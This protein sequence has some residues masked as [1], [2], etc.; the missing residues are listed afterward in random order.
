MKVLFLDESGD[1]SLITIER[2]YPLFVL[3]GV[4]VDREYARKIVEPRLREFKQHLFG[5]EDLVLHTAD[6]TRNAHGFERLQEPAFRT[7][8]YSALTDLMQELDYQVVACVIKKDLHKERYGEDARD[9]YLLSLNALL[10]RFCKELGDTRDSG[11]VIAERRRPDLDDE[12]E[13]AWNRLRREGTRYLQGEELDRRVVE[14][15]LKGK[16]LNIGGLQL[17]DLVVSPIGR[18]VLGKR[19]H[20]DWQ[21]VQQK[22]RR[23][24]GSY[25]GAGLIILPHQRNRRG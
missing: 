3:G 9:P 20:E 11:L 16:K 8:F 12:L 4:I 25:H 2:D 10:E 18:H 24:N 23:H 17:A 13:H 14:L 21:V 22:L 1:H 19:D 15:A 5:R 6:I 7:R